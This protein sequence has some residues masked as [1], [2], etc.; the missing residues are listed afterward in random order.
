MTVGIEKIVYSPIYKINIYGV[1]QRLLP[2]SVRCNKIY[3]VCDDDGY[4][5]APPRPT[6]SAA[7]ARPRWGQRIWPG[8]MA[9][10]VGGAIWWARVGHDM[11][12]QVVHVGPIWYTGV[13]GPDWVR[14]P[15][16]SPLARSFPVGGE[17]ERERERESLVYT[18]F[19][20]YIHPTASVKMAKF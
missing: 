15:P 5:S 17:R 7:V 11:A 14:L 19:F 12:G 13:V 8:G 10:R 4:A 3:M 6:I 9:G 18:F 1:R 16:T 20:L 2:V